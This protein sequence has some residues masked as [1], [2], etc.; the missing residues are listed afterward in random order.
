[1]YGDDAF[2]AA[3][4]VLASG[5]LSSNAPH[6]AVA[7]TT[8][9][10]LRVKSSDMPRCSCR[11]LT[12]E[13]RRRSVC[14]VVLTAVLAGCSQSVP[15]Q[16][17]EGSAFGTTYTVRVVGADVDVDTLSGAITDRLLEFDGRVSTWNPASDLSRLNAAQP[18]QPIP[19]DAETAALLWR[20]RE[21]VLET[22]GAFQPAVGPLVQAWN[23]GSRRTLATDA[24]PSNGDRRRLQQLASLDEPLLTI[25]GEVPNESALVVRGDADW[26]VDLSAMAKGAAVD[27]VGDLCDQAGASGWMVEIGGEVRVAGERPGGGPWRIA[28]TNPETSRPIRIVPLREVAMA[29]SGDYRNVQTIEGERVSHIIDPRTGRPAAGD[30]TSATVLADDCGTADAYATALMVMGFDEGLAWARHND[31]AVYLI[32]RTASGELVKGESPAFATRVAQMTAD[33]DTS[34]SR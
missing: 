11:C 26:E 13:G 10:D 9:Y 3:V 21:L 4:D 33:R 1:M 30:L 7:V 34:D 28:V 19:V 25:T 12:S 29:T 17:I 20:C 24:A 15:V 16:T 31:V 23:F 14:A 6:P 5:R 27:A 18:G 22:D 2:A 32:R 8:A